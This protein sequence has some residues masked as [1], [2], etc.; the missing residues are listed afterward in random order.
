MESDLEKAKELAATL[1]G[2]PGALD[3]VEA[4]RTIREL[5]DALERAREREFYGH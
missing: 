3:L 5:V 2:R 4:A 1:E